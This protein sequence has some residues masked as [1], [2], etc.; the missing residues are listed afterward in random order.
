METLDALIKK[1]GKKIELVDKDIIIKMEELKG[2]VKVDNKIYTCNDIR[3]KDLSNYA[4]EKDRTL[5]LINYKDS[6][7]LNPHKWYLNIYGPSFTILYLS[8]VNVNPEN[9]VRIEE[10]LGLREK[11]T[12][13]YQ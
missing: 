1:I 7:R 13:L 8:W 9:R 4:K 2:G 10:T 3:V 6:E 12:L 5:I 11:P